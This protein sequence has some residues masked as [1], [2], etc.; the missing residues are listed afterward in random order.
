MNCMDYLVLPAFRREVIKTLSANDAVRRA[1]IQL[2]S[3][4]ATGYSGEN[5][6]LG[7]YYVRE[8]ER[9][10]TERRQVVVY[11]VVG[12]GRVERLARTK[13]ERQVRP[14]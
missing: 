5:L 7:D 3:H 9:I 13:F 11:E 14:A 1:Q 4:R 12:T 2:F 6:V 10:G 8:V